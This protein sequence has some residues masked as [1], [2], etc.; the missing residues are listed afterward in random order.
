MKI[1]YTMILSFLL[2]TSTNSYGQQIPH[3]VNGKTLLELLNGNS[4]QKLIATGY[5]AGA[6]D[7]LLATGT[8]NICDYKNM[9]V[10]QI[11][12]TTKMMLSAA[13]QFLNGAA[14]VYIAAAMRHHYACEKKQND[15]LNIPKEKIFQL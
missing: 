1:I 8:A 14:S 15:P 13:P 9:T 4:G 6:M 7:I 5:V 10:D 3:Y 12:N 11:E 2:L